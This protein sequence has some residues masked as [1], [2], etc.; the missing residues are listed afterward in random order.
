MQ[1]IH[2][3]EKSKLATVEVRTEIDRVLGLLNF[4]AMHLE[5]SNLEAVEESVAGAINRLRALYTEL[6][7]S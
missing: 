7:E 4:A 6:D 3:L 5:R 1:N 2:S